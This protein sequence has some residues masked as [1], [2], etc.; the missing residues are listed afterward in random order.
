MTEEELEHSRLP[1][2]RLCR[3]CGKVLLEGFCDLGSHCEE[4]AWCDSCFEEKTHIGMFRRSP[5]SSDTLAAYQA[6]GV[7]PPE[8]LPNDADGYY[9]ELADG[10]WRPRE[11]VHTN[12]RHEWGGPFL[13]GDLCPEQVTLEDIPAILARCDRDE[14]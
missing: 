6:L 10:E 13:F 4:R 1:G 8:N 7:E 9:D 5:V 14:V 12:W 2:T 3:V 11:I